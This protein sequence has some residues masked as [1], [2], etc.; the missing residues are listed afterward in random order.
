MAHTLDQGTAEEIAHL[1]TGEGAAPAGR[2][3][4]ETLFGDETRFAALLR[5]LSGDPAADAYKYKNPLR[6]RVAT[7]DPLLAGLPYPLTAIA[8]QP[9]QSPKLQNL[10]F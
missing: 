5:D 7:A 6:V 3:L 9:L 2:A 10:G 1:L 4:F 8:G